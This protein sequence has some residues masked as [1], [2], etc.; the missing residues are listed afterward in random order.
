MDAAVRANAHG[1]LVAFDNVHEPEQQRKGEG[2][3]C[4][5]ALPDL[6]ILSL[7]VDP[8]FCATGRIRDSR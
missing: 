3:S 2:A 7:H 8:V 6:F 1:T 5:A 4:F